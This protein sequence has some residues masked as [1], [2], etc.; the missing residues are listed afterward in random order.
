MIT[1]A[2]EIFCR[3][4][5]AGVSYV[6]HD[7]RH[8]NVS[9]GMPRASRFYVIERDVQVVSVREGVSE[10]RVPNSYQHRRGKR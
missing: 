2:L 7:E 4:Q 9:A 6:R 3:L 5:A 10:W 8:A 1:T